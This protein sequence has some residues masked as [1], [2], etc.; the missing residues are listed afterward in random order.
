MCTR[1]T[2]AKPAD[3]IEKWFSAEFTE[4][5]LEPELTG[6]P[7]DSMPVITL[8]KPSKIQRFRFG[9]VPH[10]AKDLKMGLNNLN[11]RSE[12]LL[13]KPSFRNLP[14][15]QRCLVLTTGYIEWKTEGKMKTPYRFFL[16]EEPLFAMAGLWDAWR[17]PDGQ[18]VPSFSIITTEPN[19][20]AATVHNRMPVLLNREEARHWLD[21]ALPREEVM[22]MLHPYPAEAMGVKLF[23][24][25][26]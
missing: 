26:C 25:G 8:S 21:P 15:R 1:F 4:P 23:E 11:A 7:T 5:L 16:K 9:L 12:T 22:Q 6:A 14:G 18:L 2:L 17:A 24:K 19:E 20:L 13:E 10:W 3:E